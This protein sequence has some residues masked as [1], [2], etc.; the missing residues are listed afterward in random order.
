MGGLGLEPGTAIK[1]Q[2]LF[3]RYVVSALALYPMLVFRLRAK[4]LSPPL[5]S[6]WHG[7]R[8]SSLP[9][10][11]ASLQPASRVRAEHDE[12]QGDREAALKPELRP[13]QRL[14]GIVEVDRAGWELRTHRIVDQVR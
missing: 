5:A 8:P 10:C 11:L 2:L 9:R 12:L 7:T 14:D 1:S 4:S 6:A 3:A 13:E